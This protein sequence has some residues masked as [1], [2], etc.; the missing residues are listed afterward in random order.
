MNA[1]TPSYGL[2]GIAVINILVFTLFAFSF[3][4]PRTARDDL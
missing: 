2:W 1:A 4:R 3:A